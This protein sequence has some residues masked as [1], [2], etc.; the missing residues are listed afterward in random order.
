[1]AKWNWMISPD[2]H[3]RSALA[4]EEVVVGQDPGAWRLF[5]FPS[6]ELPPPGTAFA[7]SGGLLA[8]T[9]LLEVLD[10]HGQDGTW[11]FATVPPSEGS[12]GE[13]RYLTITYRGQGQY[14]LRHT[15]S[16]ARHPFILASAA[17]G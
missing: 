5:P 14:E 15:L 9:G 1:L 4:A 10:L 17:Q 16:S 13:P 12:T 6:I 3:P 2:T 11:W 7:D 8:A